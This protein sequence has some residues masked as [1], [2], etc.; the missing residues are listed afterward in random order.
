MGLSALT[1]GVLFLGKQRVGIVNRQFLRYAVLALMTAGLGA[2]GV[3]KTPEIFKEEFWA[4]SPLTTNTEAELGL[5]ELGMGNYA[6]AE[7]HFQKAL[8]AN[9]KDIHALLG[10]GILFQN[11]GQQVKAREMYEAILALRPD[12]SQQFVVWNTNNTRPIS[13]I[14]SVNLALLDSGSVVA[15]M[16]KG[17]AGQKNAGA[18][19]GAPMAA[20]TMGRS[21]PGT[22]VDAAN[23]APA[24]TV[25]SV[26]S[27]GDAN[28]VSRFKTLRALRDDSLLTGE[29]YASRRQANLGALL[30]LTAPPPAAGLDRPVPSSEQ[31]AGRLRAIGRALE[32]RAMTVAQHASERSMILDALMPA[33]PVAVANPGVPPKGLME[34]AD[35]VRRLEALQ[36]EGL[37][38]SDEYARERSAIE[39]AMQP[40]PT[41][42]PAAMTKVEGA[43]ADKT[44]AAT[45]KGPQPAVHLASYRS[46]EAADRGWAQIKRAHAEL[47]GKLTSEVTQIN[48]GAGKGIFYRLNAGPLADRGAAASLCDKLKRRRQFCEPTFFSGK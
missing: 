38:T 13:E 18:V 47:L 43:G 12:A 1:G 32:M 2:C 40:A 14:A 31:I 26:L 30:P 45:T 21:M 16:E 36:A 22:A 9:P 8:K 20:A 25:M 37:I 44:E 24:P 6:V 5:A 28:I 42:K 33:A 11:T 35:A 27:E 23:A 48:L 41:V 34:A 3:T 17:A 10:M 29:E 4:S 46:R 7:T 19:A 39:H 15:G